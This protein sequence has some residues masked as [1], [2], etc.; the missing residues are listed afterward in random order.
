MTFW[1]GGIYR[2]LEHPAGKACQR[3]SGEEK[4]LY[5]KGFSFNHAIGA[6][7]GAIASPAW[8]SLGEHS[9]VGPRCRRRGKAVSATSP[10]QMR[11]NRLDIGVL[12]NGRINVFRFVM[13]RWLYTT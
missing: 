7:P 8:L 1:R 9:A 4:R 10:N 11:L 13:L 6:R 2:P 5:T 3:S 12:E